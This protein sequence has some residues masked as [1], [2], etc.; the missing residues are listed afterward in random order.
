MLRTSLT[1]ISVHVTGAKEVATLSI[2]LNGLLN[3][4]EEL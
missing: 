4:L 3:E 1:T 2:H